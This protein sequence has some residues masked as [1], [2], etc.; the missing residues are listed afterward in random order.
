MASRS[1]LEREKEETS[2]VKS[3]S[4]SSCGSAS[5]TWPGGG[6]AVTFRV[7]GAGEWGLGTGV[8]SWP[9][10]RI[11]RPTANKR[12]L[13]RKTATS[14]ALQGFTSS[15]AASPMSVARRDSRRPIS[16]VGLSTGFAA[17]GSGSSSDVSAGCEGSGGAEGISVVIHEAR[18]LGGRPVGCIHINGGG[19]GGVGRAWGL[20]SE[21]R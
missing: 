14:M 18:Q 7:R 10:A 15:R 17:G 19:Q 4:W 20:G 11:R 3:T 8:V 6:E 1:Q 9:A 16:P 21:G 12:S 13:S 2:M 5:H